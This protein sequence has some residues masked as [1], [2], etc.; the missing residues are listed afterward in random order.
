MVVG[1]AVQG[2][3]Y[4]DMFPE[5]ELALLSVPSSDIVGLTEIDHVFG[6]V[7]DWMVPGGGNIVF[8]NRGSALLEP[9]VNLG[10]MLGA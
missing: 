3:I 5:S 8:P 2:G 4:G 10:T 9:G 1:N 6:R 7:C